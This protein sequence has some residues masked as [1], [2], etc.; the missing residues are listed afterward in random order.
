MRG[1]RPVLLLLAVLAWEVRDA[2]AWSRMP[3]SSWSQLPVRTTY[4]VDPSAC[5]SLCVMALQRFGCDDFRS[6]ARRAFDA[7]GR[8]SGLDAREVEWKPVSVFTSSSS[9]SSSSSS[10][11]VV[12]RASSLARREG[13]DDPNTFV[14]MAVRAAPSNASS[15]TFAA[16]TITLDAGVCWH[17]DGATCETVLSHSLLLRASAFA[18]LLLSS[19]CACFLPPSFLPLSLSAAVATLMSYFCIAQ[20]CFGC[21][22]LFGALVHEVGH[23]IGLSH[24]DEGEQTCGCGPSSAWCKGGGGGEGRGVSSSS[25]VMRRFARP[26]PSPCLS[27]DDVDAARTSYPGTVPCDDQVWCYSPSSFDGWPL[28]SVLACSLLVS[29]AASFLPL[30][31]RLFPR[32]AL[33]ASAPDAR[34]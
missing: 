18:L 5:S 1:A 21:H 16:T 10:P 9:S 11:D 14:A 13:E 25:S 6:V 2:R 34:V 22:D 12:I 4:A 31:L 32:R 15:T 30:L 7:W 17:L 24:S 8:N 23:A 19:S 20:P 33:V 26:L 27:R 29:A 28:A 3:A